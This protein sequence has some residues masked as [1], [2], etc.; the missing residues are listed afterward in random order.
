MQPKLRK[1]LLQLQEHDVA[2]AFERFLLE[3]ATQH[4]P[5]PAPPKYGTPRAGYYAF[6]FAA[7]LTHAHH[8]ELLY[9]EG[10]SRRHGADPIH[11]AWCVD[12]KGRVVDLALPNPEDGE[13]LGVTMPY[14][15]W[16]EHANQWGYWSVLKTPSRE[17]R[18]L[19]EG[20]RSTLS[21]NT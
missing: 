18:K 9:A 7:G 8:P 19:Y 2:T 21:V 17:N 16:A 4:T 20:W 3:N 13:Y 15:L 10:L 12:R 11:H 5:H 1:M 14:D 6:A